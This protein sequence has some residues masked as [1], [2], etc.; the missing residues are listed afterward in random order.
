[1]LE[2]CA[3]CGCL[4][5]RSGE[6]AQPTVRGRSH[7]T[8]HHYVAERF[9]GRSAN[10]PGETRSRIFEVCPW[11]CEGATAVYC[12]ECHEELIHNPVFLP[13]DIQRFAALVRSRGLGETE[14]TESRTA[15]AGRIKL[16]HEV[17]DAGLQALADRQAGAK[18]A[19][20]EGGQHGAF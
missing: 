11:E 20:S 16:L 7:A 1:M 5:H 6:Y 8:A 3:I 19:R 18:Y 12:Y 4:L 10:R 13:E 9:F 2:T 14:K 15:L 17:I